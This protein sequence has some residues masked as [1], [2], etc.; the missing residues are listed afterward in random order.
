MSSLRRFE[1]A[2]SLFE[3]KK[4]SIKRVMALVSRECNKVGTHYKSTQDL[5]RGC[6][7]ELDSKVRHLRAVQDSVEQSCEEL[8]SKKKFVEEGLKRLDEKEKLLKRVLQEIELKKMEFGKT[9]VSVGEQM[10]DVDLKEAEI[11]GLFEGLRLI[12]DKLNEKEKDLERRQVMID[13][14]TRMLERMRYEIDVESQRLVRRSNELDSKERNLVQREKEFAYKHKTLE[15]IN[16]QVDSEKKKGNSE[17]IKL[18]D[19]ESQTKS[20]Q[21]RRVGWKGVCLSDGGMNLEQNGSNLA[22]RYI[23]TSKNST[24]QIRPHNRQASELRAGGD[25][26]NIVVGDIW[27]CFESHDANDN[28]PRSYAQV[29]EVNEKGGVS[30]VVKWLKPCP[31]QRGEQEWINAGLPVT[32]GKFEMWR[33]SVE[34]PNI[35]SH[36]MIPDKYDPSIIIPCEGETWAVYREWNINTWASNPS[37][38]RDCKYEIVEILPYS[39][40]GCST[41]GVRVAHLDRVTESANSFK[42]RSMD[43]SI[44]ISSNSLYRFS[45]KVPS[46]KR[47]CIDEDGDL[48]HLFEVDLQ[49]L[50]REIE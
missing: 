18:E 38:H 28:M 3:E 17:N 41:R 48:P 24:G 36:R 29:L 21:V 42:R 9:S 1:E 43:D 22:Y 4:G 34:S 6:F 14:S 27:A 32:C 46:N 39:K 45:H 10:E 20:A 30:I 26:K 25:A 16:F 47:I 5:F 44:L 7:A 40:A 35:F 23:T 12:Q 13:E 8:D 49:C 37:L 50:P 19:S 15:K 31:L 11:R 2:K 33:K